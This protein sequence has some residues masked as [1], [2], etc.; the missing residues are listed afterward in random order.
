MEG[1]DICAQCHVSVSRCFVC[2]WLRVVHSVN[3]AGHSQAVIAK[4]TQ[5]KSCVERIGQLFLK[6][7]VPQRY[8]AIKTLGDCLVV[9]LSGCLLVR[10]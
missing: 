9:G 10:I 7:E 6:N 4:K 2:T 8:I 1:V 5:R 3:W